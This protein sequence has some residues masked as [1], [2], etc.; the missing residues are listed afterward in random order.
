MKSVQT[1][2]ELLEERKL[3]ETRLHNA[4]LLVNALS[5]Y[6]QI[7]EQLVSVEQLLHE[8]KLDTVVQLLKDNE[9][10]IKRLQGESNPHLLSLLTRV[11][12]RKVFYVQGV[13]MKLLHQRILITDQ[14]VSIC[15]EVH[16]TLTPYHGLSLRSILALLQQ[17]S[18]FDTALRS[19]LALLKTFSE[20]VLTTIVWVHV[21]CEIDVL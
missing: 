7:Y 9:E 12:K 2:S 4:T 5:D 19:E 20:R 6:R 17:V 11:N 1:V 15:T 8:E 3:I 16:N 21:A 10:R 18:S 13:L 14:S